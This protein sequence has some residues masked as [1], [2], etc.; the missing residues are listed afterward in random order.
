[1]KPFAALPRFA[2]YP[3]DFGFLGEGFPRTKR[4][5]FVFP[6]YWLHSFRLPL[7]HLVASFVLTKWVQSV[8]LRRGKGSNSP[9]WS[10]ACSSW[11]S[12]LDRDIDQSK[13]AKFFGLDSP[14]NKKTEYIEQCH[15][16]HNEISPDTD[17]QSPVNENWPEVAEIQ[18]AI[19]NQR[20]H[21]DVLVV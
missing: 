11:W 14:Q 19:N 8:D 20:Q 13:R 10:C 5:R 21:S 15:I 9:R 1:M 17:Y 16:K 3:F 18:N 4:T 2:G 12:I 6:I 7:R